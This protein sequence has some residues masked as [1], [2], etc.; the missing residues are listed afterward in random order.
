VD[1]TINS[2]KYITMISEDPYKE[3]DNECYICLE[4]CTTKSTCHCNTHVHPH[5]LS[6]FQQLSGKDT[7]CDICLEPYT[8]PK[9]WKKAWLFTLL[10]V[11]CFTGFIVYCFTGFIGQLIF[12]MGNSALQ[13]P[14]SLQHLLCSI[15]ICIIS[16]LFYHIVMKCRHR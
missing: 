7:H 3:I 4:S 2:R 13:V 15:V 16:F 1:S 9:S 8:H 5:C 6:T 12:T 14:W 10:I 11:Y